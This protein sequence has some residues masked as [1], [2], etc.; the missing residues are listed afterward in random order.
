[1]IV[2]IDTSSI[3][4]ILELG[5]D[6]CDICKQLG[7][8]YAPRAVIREL[9]VLAGRRRLVRV[10]LQ[11]V[12]DCLEVVEVDGPADAV[13]LDL[14]RRLG[15]AVMSGDRVIRRKARLMG[16]AVVSINEK[17]VAIS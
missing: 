12:H 15:A 11:L 16:L 7:K 13:V 17:G 2:I 1:M 4:R 3:L 9:E 6:I 8:C 10:A 5:F 14:A